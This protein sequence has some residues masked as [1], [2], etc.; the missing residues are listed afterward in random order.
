[1]FAIIAAAGYGTRFGNIKKQFL[2]INDR[3]ILNICVE[4]FI[5]CGILNIVVATAKE[6]MKLA[7]QILTKFKNNIKIVEGGM[8]RQE[9]VKKAFL[10]H[11]KNYDKDDLVLVHDAVRPFFDI[12]KLKKLINTAKLKKAAIL[13]CP[14]FDT[15][16][17]AKNN[18]IIN[19]LNR[20][21]I[22]LSQTPQA[23]TIELYK[24]ALDLSQ[25]QN[26]NYT[27]DAELIEITKHPI[28]IVLSYKDNFK[29]TTKQDLKYI[30]FLMQK[31][32]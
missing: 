23:F 12:E 27:D 3:F 18:Q 9:T 14:V 11:Y 13:A 26:L 15:V 1:M 5:K 7:A 21:K 6:D 22:F 29:I 8:T 28:E 20:T 17:Y 24:K 31:E 25:N 2:K 4:K 30:N 16:K 32:L 10:K 19:S